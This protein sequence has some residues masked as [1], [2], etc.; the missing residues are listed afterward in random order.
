MLI[1][2]HRVNTIEELALVPPE[3]GV[4][5]DVRRN[6]RT[7]RLYLNH[8]AGEGEDLDKYL[9]EFNQAFIIFNIKEAGTESQCIKLAEKYFVPKERYFLLDVEF[10]YLYR[11]SREDGVREIAVRFS[12]SEP[13][14]MALAQ[15]G[16]VDW[17]WIDTVTRLP[18]DEEAVK[19]L[20]GFK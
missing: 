16:F 18:L 11:A 6:E 3:R 20:S 10:P 13:I 14:E 12:E 5:I 17:V 9:R 19:R 15:K 7:G 8:D 4:E 2:E 1:I